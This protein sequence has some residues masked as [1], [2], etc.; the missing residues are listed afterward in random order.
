MAG[1]PS[2]LLFGSLEGVVVNQGVVVVVNNLDFFVD[3]LLDVTQVLFLL[4]IAK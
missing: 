4:G 2:P 3:Q 1:V